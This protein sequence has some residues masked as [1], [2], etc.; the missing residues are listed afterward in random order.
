MSITAD[1][2]RKLVGLLGRLGSDNDNERLAAA[3]LIEAGRKALGMQWEDLIVQPLT[4]LAYKEGPLDFNTAR[5]AARPASGKA[6]D[7]F[8]DLE[9]FMDVIERAELGADT[10]KEID[11]AADMRE[12]AERYG[13][14][15][16]VS[17]AQLSWLTA[18]AERAQ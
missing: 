7:I 12:R 15:T 5:P 4:V 10:P 14:N 1:A 8:E 18:L 11:F 2:R 13:M 3:K 6:V 16:F 17:E 9:A